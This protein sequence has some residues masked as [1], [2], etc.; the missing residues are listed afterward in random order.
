MLIN[1]KSRR[2]GLYYY[3]ILHSYINNKA[4]WQSLELIPTYKNQEQNRWK[5][6]G[7]D[8]DCIYYNWMK[9]A[10][11][12]EKTRLYRYPITSILK[13]QYHKRGIL[14]PIY[15]LYYPTK[16]EGKKQMNTMI[17][18]ET[19]IEYETRIVCSR[20]KKVVVI[21]KTKIWKKSGSFTQNTVTLISNDRKWKA[22]MKSIFFLWWNGVG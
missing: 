13:W 15:H 4:I 5:W 6:I 12:C 1:T 20:T 3:V 8:N 14:F 7:I 9:V 17:V 22:T 16:R 18:I 21:E 19:I 10:W 11:M 2:H